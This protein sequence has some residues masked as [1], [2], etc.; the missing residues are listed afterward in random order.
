MSALQTIDFHD[1]G[2]YLRERNLVD[3]RHLQAALCRCH[4]A[5]AHFRSLNP[6]SGSC[7]PSFPPISWQNS[8]RRVSW[9]L[10]DPSCPPNPL[11]MP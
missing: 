4:V 6:G 11:Q 2:Q 7:S 9:S 5:T 3:E 10:A 8:R 1:V